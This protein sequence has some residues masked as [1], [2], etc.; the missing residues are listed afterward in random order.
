MAS[1]VQS[2]NNK[3]KEGMGEEKK[4]VHE[5]KKWKRREK[6]RRKVELKF[7]KTYKNQTQK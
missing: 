3:D 7:Q 4:K 5:K 6:G 2:S 1:Q